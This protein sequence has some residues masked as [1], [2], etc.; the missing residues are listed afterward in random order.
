MGEAN[1]AKKKLVENRELHKKNKKESMLSNKDVDIM[2]GP[3]DQKLGKLH[4]KIK[5]IL[6]IKGFGQSILVKIMSYLSNN[7][8]GGSDDVFNQRK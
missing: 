6:T 3:I 2:M 5:E 7:P 8:Y 4:H 1:D